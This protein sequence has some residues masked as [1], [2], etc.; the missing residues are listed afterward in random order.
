MQRE[1]VKRPRLPKGRLLVR[2]TVPGCKKSCRLTC[3]A[4]RPGFSVGMPTGGEVAGDAPGGWWTR[5]LSVLQY[6]G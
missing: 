5:V 4:E 1:R 3:G 2:S 6:V